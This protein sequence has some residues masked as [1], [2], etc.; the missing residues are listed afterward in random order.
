M[1][2]LNNKLTLLV[3]AEDNDGKAIDV[4]GIEK[5]LINT[6]GGCTVFDAKGDW[7]SGGRIYGDNIK[8]MQV[9]YADVDAEAIQVVFAKMI[10]YLFDWG[11]QKAVSVESYNGLTIYN[12]KDRKMLA[13]I[14]ADDRKKRKQHL[15]K[16]KAG[17]L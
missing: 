10:I 6:A 9:N 8:A 13:Q 3:P 11:G 14:I 16:A 2:L 7:V 17:T 12:K 1:E 4:D 5:V 15:A